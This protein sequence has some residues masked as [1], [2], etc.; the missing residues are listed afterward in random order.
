MVNT[1]LEINGTNVPIIKD[2]PISLNYSV[3]DIR[4]PDNVK[5]SFS[6]TIQVPMSKEVNDLFELIFEV[7]VSLQTFNPNLK[8]DAVFYKEE[9]PQFKGSAQVLSIIKKYDGSTIPDHYE[10]NLIGESGD[11]FLAMGDK[12]LTDINFSDLNHAF[13]SANLNWTPTLGTGYTYPF[14]DYGFTQGNNF[15]WS[16]QNLKPA[17]FVREYLLRMFAALGYSW[18]PGCFLDTTFFKSLI[19]PDSNEGQ[20]KLPDAVVANS[21][22]YA[23]RISDAAVS[24]P[25][26][27]IGPDWTLGNYGSPVPNTQIVLA[28]PNDT[29]TPFNDP[30][31]VYSIV[32]NIFTAPTNANYDIVSNQ[33]FRLQFNPPAGTVSLDIFY[34]YIQ[35][36]LIVEIHRSTDGGATWVTLSQNTGI[37]NINSLGYFDTAISVGLSNYACFTGNQFRV[38]WRFATSLSVAFR[39]IYNNYISTGSF[40]LGITY[41]SGSPGSTFYAKLSSDLLPYGGTVIMNQTVPKNIKQ[42]DF[43]KS[44]IQM[45]NLR[46]EPDRNNPKVLFIETHN[47]FYND[48]SQAL[49]WTLKLDVGREI[50]ITP[51]GELDSRTYEWQYK[52]DSDAFNKNYFDE[53]KMTY[54]KMFVDITNDFIKNTKTTEVIFSA[55]PIASY[56]SN[57]IIC[58]R[59]Y[60]QEDLTNPTQIKNV[61]VNIRI[62]YWAGLKSCNQFNWNVN[63]T[64]TQLTQYPFAGHVND[65]Q[66]PTL[67]LSFRYPYRIYWSIPAQA[68]TNNA[69]YNAYWK[70]FIEEITDKDSKLIKAWFNLNEVD[71]GKFTF[72]NLIYC[73]LGGGGAYYYVN[74]IIDYNP[75]ERGITQVELLKVKQATPFVAEIIINGNQ[76]GLS[77]GQNYG[78]VSGEVYEI[79]PF[80]PG[81]NLQ[82]NMNNGQSFTYGLNNQNNGGLIIGNDNYIG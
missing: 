30:G 45:F 10:I 1:R 27:Y 68:Y 73:D 74:K 37:V 17:I 21:E 44:I 15:N 35:V 19:I 7:N 47:S 50:E 65:T 71:I 31:N 69:L 55:T 41:K 16:F 33:T 54:G 77:L 63:G 23:G 57:N 72:R 43:F 38:A 2:F 39:D 60:Q 36:N 66:Y 28:F 79:Q 5:S 20:L 64:I 9:I 18:T 13:T 12:Y 46:L 51:M 14:I 75:L 8:S 70:K 62:L 53:F 25:G 56:P 6:K 26:T 29:T 48:A 40:S 24:F 22:F 67:D 49:D 42:K 52:N 4:S 59:F 3:T 78:A 11:I 80:T 81:N 58:P 76:T 34:S 82:N 61:K 32:S